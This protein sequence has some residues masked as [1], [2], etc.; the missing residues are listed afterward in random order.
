MRASIRRLPP[1]A[2]LRR[3]LDYIPST[4]ALIWKTRPPTSKYNLG[5]NR[6][7]A[8]KPAGSVS[9]NA[10]RGNQYPVVGIRHN[11]IYQQYKAHRVIWKMM[12]GDEPPDFI[13]HKDG[14]AFNLK[15]CNLRAASNA[16]NLHNAKLRTDNRSGVK[17]VFWDAPHKKWRAV[18]SVN[19]QSFRLG[20]YSTVEEAEAVISRKRHEL[21]GEF[22]RSL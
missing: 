4:G 20:R 9:G 15:W 13:D 12:T 14:D 3:L 7:L 8:G 11:G 18:I 19:K 21:H 16:Q 2:F 5:F 17:G 6:R 1:R 10:A 22:S